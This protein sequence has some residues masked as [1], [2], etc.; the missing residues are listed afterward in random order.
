MTIATSTCT[1]RQESSQIAL[2]RDNDQFAGN[3][4][5]SDQSQRVL[6]QRGSKTVKTRCKRESSIFMQ[7][8]EFREI[9]PSTCTHKSSKSIKSNLQKSVINSCAELRDEADRN[10]HLQK[11]AARKSSCACKRL[12]NKYRRNAPERR[13]KTPTVRSQLATCLAQ[14]PHEAN[15]EER[16]QRKV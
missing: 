14:N 13:H 8:C 9:A 2:T 1:K 10:Q 3:A 4:A 12:C 5:R 6:A 7:S 15:R 16:I 11:E